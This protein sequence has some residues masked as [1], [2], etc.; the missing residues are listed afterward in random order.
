MGPGLDGLVGPT[1]VPLP[2]NLLGDARGLPMLLL[3][4]FG[5]DFITINITKT[6]WSP[7]FLVSGS[8]KGVLSIGP[9]LD[10]LVGPT[11]VPLPCNLLGD[12]RGLPML[13][14]AALGIES[15]ELELW[16]LLKD[17]GLLGLDSLQAWLLD[18]MDDEDEL[19]DGLEKE[20]AFWT[21]VLNCRKWLWKLHLV[22]KVYRV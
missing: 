18:L 2:C 22:Y 19:C 1:E 8:I 13:L 16:F 11:D 7:T 9:G 5:M 12:A 14:L 17:R 10:G 4:D 3:A 20:L 15:A 6:E 21:P